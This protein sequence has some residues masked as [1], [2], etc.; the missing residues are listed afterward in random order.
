MKV[1]TQPRLGEV[2]H[3]YIRVL[4]DGENQRS[5]VTLD[6]GLNNRPYRSVSVGDRHQTPVWPVEEPETTGRPIVDEA[7]RH[8]YVL[9]IIRR[10]R[11][12]WAKSIS[13][14]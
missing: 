10:S 12:R 5:A 6:W 14:R 13:R 8:G 1:E 3:S 2:R 9:I 11:L 4:V 7:A